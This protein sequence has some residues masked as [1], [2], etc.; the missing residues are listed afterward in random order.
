M[1]AT[2]LVANKLENIKEIPFGCSSV[3]IHIFVN[4]HRFTVAV[5]A[6]LAAFQLQDFSLAQMLY[7]RREKTQASAGLHVILIESGQS[8]SMSSYKVTL[9]DPFI[10]A[11]ESMDHLEMVPCDSGLPI[12]SYIRAK[13]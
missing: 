9:F 3:V 1:K 6:I 10:Q 2:M 4:E 7:I 5:A 12:L 8:G 13:P 11:A